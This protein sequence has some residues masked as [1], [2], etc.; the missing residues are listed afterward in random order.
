MPRN[1]ESIYVNFAKWDATEKFSARFLVLIKMFKETFEVESLPEDGQIWT[2]CG[3]QFRQSEEI[4]G[5]LAHLLSENMIQQHQYFGI[6]RELSIIEQNKKIW[7]NANWIHGDFLKVLENVVMGGNFNPSIIN[8]DGVMQPINSSGYLKKILNLIDWNVSGELM[9]VANYVL[10]NPYLGN[11]KKLRFTVHDMLEELKKVYDMPD[12]WTVYP[13]SFAYKHSRA[14][15]GII[16]L[17]KQKHDIKK[18]NIIPNYEVGYQ[19]AIEISIIKDEI[20]IVEEKKKRASNM[21]ADV[22]TWNP[23]KGCKFDCSYCKPSFQAQAKRQKNRCSNC[24]NFIP[25]THPDRLDKIPNAD[26]IFVCGN[27]DISFCDPN[28]TV[29]IINSIKK[30]IVKHPQK[31]FFLQSKRP[32]YF[33]KFLK[34]L[35]DNIKLVTTLETNRDTGYEK[36]SK[37][38][39]PSVRYAQFEELEYSHKILT[40][41]PIMDFD[42]SNFMDMVLSINPELVWLGINS[43]HKQVQLPEPSKEKFYE[44]Y[45]TLIANDINVK[46]MNEYNR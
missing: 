42:M 31:K 44:L 23:F 5:E 16:V 13:E 6:D 34:T 35:P 20:K 41:E 12:H 33:K 2:L 19:E 17:I 4:F 14:N 24:Y 18:I 26:T 7:P 22:K 45:N 30:N 36:V 28:F 9:L 37:A 29:E 15:M 39:I 40:I 43:R 8:Y 27:G 25:H 11:S 46:F 3:S 1:S 10:T 32:E 21:Y 38:T